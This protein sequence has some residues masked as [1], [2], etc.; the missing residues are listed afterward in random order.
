MEAGE[1]NASILEITPDEEKEISRK[2]ILVSFWWFETI[3]ADRLSM[4]KVVEMMAGS[5]ESIEIPPKPFLFSPDQKTPHEQSILQGDH[6]HGDQNTCQYPDGIA[7]S[8]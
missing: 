3:P 8:N 5:L 7:R 4:R 6:E 2:M 1:N